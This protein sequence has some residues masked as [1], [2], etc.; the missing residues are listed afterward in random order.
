MSMWSV[1]CGVRVASPV[2]PGPP[3]PRSAADE[4]RRM[5]LCL[6]MMPMGHVVPAPLTRVVVGNKTGSYGAHMTNDCLHSRCNVQIRLRYTPM[7][8]AHTSISVVFD[9]R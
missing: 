5:G 9:V 1:V 2:P 4:T 8:V 6:H 7:I 3:A